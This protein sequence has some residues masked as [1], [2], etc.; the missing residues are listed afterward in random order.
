MFF[1]KNAAILLFVF[2]VGSS[3]MLPLVASAATYSTPNLWPTGYWGQ[4]GLVSCTGDYL[5]QDNNAHPCTSL[6]DLINTFINI[7]YFLM[8]IAIFV[9][10]PILLVVGGIMIMLAGA[11][12]GMLESGKKV[13]T[14]AVIGLIIVLC[15]YL[16]V[17]TVVKV[18]GVTDVGGFG[19]AAC[20]PD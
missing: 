3:V 13:L 6:C 16:I 7:V 14:G 18:L 20:T 15:S 2:V 11:N 19:G 10:A 17:A 8:T 4:G 1:K 12:P 5:A 9:I